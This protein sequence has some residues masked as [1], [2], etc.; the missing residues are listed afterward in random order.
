MHLAN[1]IYR[2]HVCL[3]TLTPAVKV[4]GSDE[5]ECAADETSAATV[6]IP[7]RDLTVHRPT[8]ASE[9]FKMAGEKGG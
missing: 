1:V 7:H 3:L 9:F 4:E 5:D 2:S 6:G 8:T